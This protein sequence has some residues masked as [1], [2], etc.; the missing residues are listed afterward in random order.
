MFDVKQSIIHVSFQ[1]AAARLA[2]L[3]IL[4]YF[5]TNPFAYKAGAF[6]LVSLLQFSVSGLLKEVSAIFSCLNR[7]NK[8]CVNF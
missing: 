7:H 2:M 3:I 4:S 6:S 8:L 1:L 5:H